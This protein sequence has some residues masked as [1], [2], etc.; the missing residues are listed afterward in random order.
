LKSR[1]Q[2]QGS[3]DNPLKATIKGIKDIY[4]SKADQVSLPDKIDLSGKTIMITG[5]SSG[6]GLATAKEMAVAGGKV[7]MAVR[8]G[9]PEKGRSITKKTGNQ[10]VHMYYVDLS[11]FDSIDRLLYKLEKDKV[12]VDV[13]V[14][15]AAVVPLSSRTTPQ[16][17]E[18]MFMVNYLSAFYMINKL[19]D[20][21]ILKSESRVIIVSSESHRNR[22]DFEWNT[23]GEYEEYGANKSVA[24]YGY[25]KLLLTTFAKELTRKIRQ[26]RLQINVYSLCPGPVNSNIAR[27]APMWMKPLLRAIFSLFFKSPEK[28][29]EPIL[30]FAT[31]PN[32]P[33]SGDLEYMFRMQEK[34][35]SNAAADPENG[36]ELWSMSI[37]LISKVHKEN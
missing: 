7:I 17:L 3:Y 19:I 34:S 14:S 12:G 32:N 27:E 4:R 5:S 20:K 16:G 15:N 21:E 13:L 31:K 23:F 28:A 33:A 36:A 1:N 18:E 24:K 37:D 26:L 25:T 30:Y 9:I 35:I 8:S 6:L 2:K 11:D 29:C 10:N 22:D